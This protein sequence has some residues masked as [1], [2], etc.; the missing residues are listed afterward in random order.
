MVPNIEE[1][2]ILLWGIVFYIMNI[3]LLGSTTKSATHPDPSG[4]HQDL[5]VIETSGLCDPGRT[6]ME[7][8]FR[9]EAFLRNPLKRASGS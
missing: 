4:P 3:I 1:D 9:A 7:V 6:C 2:W 8:S 5:I